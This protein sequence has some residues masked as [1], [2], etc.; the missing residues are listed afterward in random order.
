[1]VSPPSDDDGNKSRRSGSSL[2]P[3]RSFVL[4]LVGAGVVVLWMHDPRLGAAV[5]AGVTVL[6]F[7]AK[8]VK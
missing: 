2:L 6:G 1:M 3:L 7:L 5:L 4:L 8:V